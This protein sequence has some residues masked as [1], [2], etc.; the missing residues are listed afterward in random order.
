MRRLD[1]SREIIDG[2]GFVPF[3]FIV[4]Y[5]MGFEGLS[6]SLF[7]RYYGFSDYVWRVVWVDPCDVEYNFLKYLDLGG[8]NAICG[9]AGGNWDKLREPIENL[10]R[11]SFEMHFVEGKPWSE[12]PQ[13][14]RSKRRLEKGKN[15]VNVDPDGSVMDRFEN[16][17]RIY[18]SLKENG[19][20]PR[21]E[22]NWREEDEYGYSLSG[23]RIPDEPKIA[24]GRNG[25]LMHIDCGSH[26][27]ALAQIL[28]IDRIPA[29]VQLEHEEW[30]G[31]LDVIEE[32]G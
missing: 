2:V 5:K 19:Y 7:K 4:M 26:R 22:K 32:L 27:L 13:Y 17:E 18:D 30:D 14:S 1:K 16:V 29:V 9:C 3:L 20:V 10:Y 12:T 23:V 8:K 25:E 28:D 31:E 11:E 6:T 21:L 15:V 24:V